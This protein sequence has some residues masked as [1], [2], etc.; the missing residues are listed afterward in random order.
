MNTLG[1]AY[2]LEALDLPSLN[3]FDIFLNAQSQRDNQSLYGF[4]GDRWEDI[5]VSDPD[6]FDVRIRDIKQIDG[7]L[8]VVGGYRGQ[9][10]EDPHSVSLD[11]A[12]DGFIAINRGF[13]WTYP[14]GSSAR[15]YRP[16]PFS[17]ITPALGWVILPMRMPY[18][19]DSGS[20]F[21]DDRVGLYGVDVAK[22]SPDAGGTLSETLGFPVDQI[23]TCGFGAVDAAGEGLPTGQDYVGAIYYVGIQTGSDVNQTTGGWCAFPP[24]PDL[25]GQF[26]WRCNDANHISNTPATARFGQTTDVGQYDLEEMLADNT[27]VGPPSNTK[28][29]N[30]LVARSRYPR[31]FLSIASMEAVLPFGEPLGVNSG[32]AMT[33][34]GDCF[35]ESGGATDGSFPLLIYSIPIVPN[36]SNPT[37]PVLSGRTD[38]NIQLEDTTVA[39][40]LEGAWFRFV[41]PTTDFIISGTD[42][43]ELKCV[44]ILAENVTHGAS[45]SAEI[46]IVSGT[47]GDSGLTAGQVPYVPAA[48][49]VAGDISIFPYAVSGGSWETA[50]GITLPV[51]WTAVANQMRTFTVDEESQAKTTFEAISDENGT[52]VGQFNNYSRFGFNNSTQEANSDPG[53]PT[54]QVIVLMGVTISGAT[55]T[56]FVLAIDYGTISAVIDTPGGAAPFDIA[57]TGYSADYGVTLRNQIVSGGANSYPVSA[58]WDNDRDQW[59]FIYARQSGSFAVISC[60]SDFQQFIDQTDNLAIFS[61]TMGDPSPTKPS[62]DYTVPSGYSLASAGIYTARLMTNE[63][64]G[65]VIGGDFEDM[66]DSTRVSAILPFTAGPGNQPYNNFTVIRGSTGR[67]ARVWIDYVL[68]DGV[69]SLVATKLSELG[70]RVTPENVEWFKGRILRS[71]GVDEL[72]IKTEEIE[73]WMEAQRKEYTDMLRTKERSGRLRKRRS[74]VSAYRDGVEGALGDANK[75]SVDTRALD[76]EDLDDLLRDVGMPDD[77]YSSDRERS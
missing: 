31:R 43:E 73:Q 12:W 70:L 44:L 58:S 76:P 25:S 35:A 9:F 29:T 33:I 50:T 19:W 61:G 72:D 69:D 67:I 55:H 42:P 68:Y 51:R 7:C 36:P 14:L 49:P 66:T 13:T 28:P 8:V 30:T 23:V 54:N 4:Y 41:I 15:D 6:E 5:M 45:T 75:S 64:D 39:Y 27:E 37:Y 62:F 56:P 10:I 71:A 20:G 77:G 17:E 11:Y 46:Y 21:D 38:E 3:W 48:D 57:A 74:Q 24:A 34:V 26:T 32:G 60:R 52:A 16:E 40:D 59:L 65:I 1:L 22:R 47:A 53:S 18:E 2:D 63:L